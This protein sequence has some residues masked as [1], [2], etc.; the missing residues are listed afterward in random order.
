MFIHLFLSRLLLY[1]AL[2]STRYGDCIREYTTGLHLYVNEP[3]AQHISFG[4][5]WIR[6]LRVPSAVSLI[7][8]P[9]LEDQQGR[10]RQL[11]W[12]C[13]YLIKIQSL[14]WMV[15]SFYTTKD[16][17]NNPTICRTSCNSNCELSVLLYHA[18]RFR[19]KMPLVLKKYIKRFIFFIKKRRVSH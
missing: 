16:W 4:R 17:K 12:F 10:Y 18:F 3:V 7:R 15:C 9:S 13:M 11:L 5:L 6:N 19:L 2:P 1:T 14:M 8:F